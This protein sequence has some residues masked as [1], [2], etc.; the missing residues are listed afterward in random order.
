MKRIN[1]LLVIGAI[2]FFGMG[3]LSNHLFESP[4]YL[5]PQVYH[6]IDSLKYEVL[7][8]DSL[9]FELESQIDVLEEG[10]QFRESEISYW[11]C[12]YDSIKNTNNP[13]R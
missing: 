8:K 6:E 10:I 4:R 13:K 5:N 3:W 11:G 9:I 7:S 2:W 1:V 12:K